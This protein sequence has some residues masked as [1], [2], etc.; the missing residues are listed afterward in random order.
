[1]RDDVEK[2]LQISRGAFF[3]DSEKDDKGMEAFSVRA[4]LD[5]IKKYKNEEWTDNLA[6]NLSRQF[7][8]RANQQNQQEIA[9]NLKRQTGVDIEQFVFGG[10]KV[11]QR[12]E[13]LMLANTQLIK[14]IPTQYLDKV[15][16]AVTRGLVS[17]KLPK[18]IAEEIKEIGRVTD[19]R[20]RLIARDQ[21]SKASSALTQARHEELGITRYRWSASGD[22]R[23]RE[24]HMANDGKIFSYDNPPPTGH[25]GHEVNCRCVAIAVFDEKPKFGVV[26]TAIAATTAYSFIKEISTKHGPTLINEVTAIEPLERIKQVNDIVDKKPW[27][28]GFKN[29]VKQTYKDFTEAGISVSMHGIARYLDRSRHKDDNVLNAIK[30][31]LLTTKANYVDI[32]NGNEVL[33]IPK[34]NVAVISKNGIVITFLI[35]KNPKKSWKKIK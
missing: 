25:P 35:M 2:A 17:G 6:N 23:V 21:S 3:M 10:N 5:F 33:F 29:K 4:F 12:L 13:G 32:D 28:D 31:E 9:D 22:E 16:S 18:D 7:A 15:Q 19:S 14:S 27:S 26:E 8:A 11:A 1:M 24:S 30:H 34:H 20:A